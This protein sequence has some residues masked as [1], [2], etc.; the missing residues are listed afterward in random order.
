MPFSPPSRKHDEPKFLSLPG[1]KQTLSVSWHQ[2]VV[3]QGRKEMLPSSG[4]IVLC[5]HSPT[6]D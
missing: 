1:Y 4:Q 5:V 2:V 3:R 6:L